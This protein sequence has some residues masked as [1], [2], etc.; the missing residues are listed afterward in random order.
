MSEICSIILLKFTNFLIGAP[1][2]SCLYT[3]KCKIANLPS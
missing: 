1:T 3:S 2:N